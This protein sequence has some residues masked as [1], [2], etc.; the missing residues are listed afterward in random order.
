MGMRKLII[1]LVLESAAGRTGGGT[2]TQTQMHAMG[3][4][5]TCRLRYLRYSVA[6]EKSR[7]LDRVQALESEGRDSVGGVRGMLI[8][9]VNGFLCT[10]SDGR[11][12]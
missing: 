1:W 11:L 3:V 9:I 4:V 12:R 10:T 2:Q 7:R 5:S 8:S 6:K